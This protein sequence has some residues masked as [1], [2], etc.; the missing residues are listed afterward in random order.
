MAS[1]GSRNGVGLEVSHLGLEGEQQHRQINNKKRKEIFPY[2]N[3]KN[4]YGYQIGQE[5]EEDARLK[6]FQEGMP[7]KLEAFSNGVLQR[8]SPTKLKAFLVFPG[9]QWSWDR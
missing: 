7:T 9:Y 3:H 6:G 8:L 5:M 1:F 2:G 4:Y